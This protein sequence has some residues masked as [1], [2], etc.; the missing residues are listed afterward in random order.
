MLASSLLDLKIFNVESSIFIIEF[1]NLTA[2]YFG[3]YICQWYSSF[4]QRLNKNVR[5]SVH[6]MNAYANS[7]SFS[8]KLLL[9]EDTFF[10]EYLRATALSRYPSENQLRKFFKNSPES[11]L[12]AWRKSFLMM[13]QTLYVKLH[14]NAIKLICFPTNFEKLSE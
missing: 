5:Y 1:E 8:M 11:T 13:L 2:S 3:L 4:P 10:T 12:E 14:K 7:F 6:N 9:G